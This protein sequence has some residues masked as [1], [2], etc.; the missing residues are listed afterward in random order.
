MADKQQLYFGLLTDIKSRVQ[1]AQ[2]RAMLSVNAELIHLYWDIGKLIHE[3]QRQEGWGAAVIPR[4]AKD[5]HNELPEVK[6]FS[7]RN[8]KRMLAFYRAYEDPAVFVPRAVA[9]TLPRAKGP[10]PVAQIL[11]RIHMVMYLSYVESGRMID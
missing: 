2:V 7:E 10:Q 1:Q 9:Q 6:G 3:R 5:L 4:L 11:L 8:I